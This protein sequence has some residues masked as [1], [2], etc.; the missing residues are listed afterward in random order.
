MTTKL[1]SGLT[2]HEDQPFRW[3]WALGGSSASGGARCLEDAQVWTPRCIGVGGELTGE[4]RGGELRDKTSDPGVRDR[5]F[6]YA[7]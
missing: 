2:G 4:P 6:G 5:P 3:W 1:V 7:E